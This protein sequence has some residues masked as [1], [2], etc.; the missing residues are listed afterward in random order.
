MTGNPQFLGI[1]IAY[2]LPFACHL[3]TR[4]FVRGWWKVLLIAQVA[5]MIVMLIWTGSRTGAWRRRSAC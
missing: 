2:T 5:V 3:L 4:P 1:I